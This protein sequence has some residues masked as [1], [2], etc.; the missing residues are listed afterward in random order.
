M[1]VSGVRFLYSATA[2]GIDNYVKTRDKVKTQFLTMADKF[3]G[4]MSEYAEDDSKNMI[5]TEDLKNM[6][7][8]VESNDNDLDLIKRMMIRYIIC[9]VFSEFQFMV[10]WQLFLKLR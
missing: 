9:I 3:R 2:L 10:F 6:L 7:H 1:F 8:L 4:K 5:F